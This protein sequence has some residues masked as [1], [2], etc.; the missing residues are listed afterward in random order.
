MH[1]KHAGNEVTHINKQKFL[2]ELSKFLTFLTDEER[3]KVLEKFEGLFDQN[4]NEEEILANMESPLKITVELSRAFS[5]G[6]L[7]E[8]LLFCEELF[9]G[10]WK[11]AEDAEAVKEEVI[12]AIDG[13]A[14]KAVDIIT[15][16][17]PV[18]VE[19]EEA[20]A[21]QNPL[22]DDGLIAVFE[23]D[24]KEKEE[25]AEAVEKEEMDPLSDEEVTS[26]EYTLEP[27]KEDADEEVAEEVAE[28]LEDV[29][30]VDAAEELKQGTE[31]ENTSEISAEEEVMDALEKKFSDEDKDDIVREVAEDL[32]PDDAEEISAQ[33]QDGTELWHEEKETRYKARIWALIPYA[34]IA[35]PLGLIGVIVCAT[36]TGA[37]LAVAAALVGA[38]VM[39]ASLAI[40]SGMSV[41]ADIIM[42]IG[43]TLI[44]LGLSL[45]VIWLAVWFAVNTI[46]GIVGGL[47]RL[48][49]KW[50][51]K[52]V[53][54]A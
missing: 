53:E 30:V 14:F 20:P 17:T 22:E 49:R 42:T 41:L 1:K 33:P 4:G 6:G 38:V 7:N 18:S 51:Y 47:Y 34:I 43:A 28:A 37:I 19:E 46:G 40:Q 2:T 25:A 10:N 24:I 36:I 54:V 44:A 9:G 50:C 5:K 31:E 52:E 13:D 26:E 48:G 8:V 32:E 27:Q 11:P 16:N 15:E 45:L 3:D 12:Q 21:V 23:Q 29:A 39:G 35:I